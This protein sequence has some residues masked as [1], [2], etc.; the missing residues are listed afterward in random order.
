MRELGNG[1]GYLDFHTHILPGID[2]GASTEEITKQMLRE[3]YRQGVRTIMATPHNYP[4]GKNAESQTVIELCGKANLWAKEIAADLEV[5][6]GNEIYYRESICEEIAAGKILTMADSRYVLV[7]FSPGEGFVKVYDGCRK[8]IERGYYPVIAHIERIH[9][10]FSK[11][12]KIEELIRMGCYMQANCEDFMGGIFDRK[13]ARL[14]RYLEC[15]YL[16]FLGSDCH[17]MADRVPMMQECIDR[18]YKKVS[19]QAVDQ[20][21]YENPTK[22]LEKKCI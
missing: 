18:L 2:D 7:E 12:E 15:G 16:H 10:V 20:V 22:F 17:N 11:E 13:A 21:I 9:G 3:A 6:S 1:A 14:F 19:K 8:L 5:L 4:G